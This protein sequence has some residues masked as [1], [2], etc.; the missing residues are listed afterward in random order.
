MQTLES[1]NLKMYSKQMT[2]TRK[3]SVSLERYSRD[4]KFSRFYTDDVPG[5]TSEECIAKLRDI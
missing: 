3:F 2:L 1:I 4:Y 5:S